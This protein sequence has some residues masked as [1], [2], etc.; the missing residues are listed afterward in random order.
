ME[1]NIAKITYLYETADNASEKVGGEK[2]HL[3]TACRITFA[4]CP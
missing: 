4:D 1:I 3:S 2:A